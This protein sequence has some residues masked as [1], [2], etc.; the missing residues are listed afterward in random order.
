MK[1]IVKLLFAAAFAALVPVAAFAQA[2]SYPSRPIKVIVPFAPGGG[3]DAIARIV[4]QEMSK[5]LGQPIVVEHRT[6]AAGIIGI[7][8]AAKADPDGYTL[9]VLPGGHPLYSATYKMLPFDVVKSFD[10]VSTATT[11]PFV[12][13]VRDDSKIRTLADL[14]AE[15]KAKP[16]GLTFGNSGAGSTHQFT[17][18]LIA[19]R[20]GTKFISVP[21]QGE[22]AATTALLGGQID[23]LLV[24]PTQILSH[25]ESGK[26]RPLAVTGNTRFSKLPNVPT[27]EEAIGLKG[28]DI[29]TWFGLAGPAG[30]PNDVI[31]RLNAEM[32]KALANPE[33]RQRLEA[34]GG[35]ISPSTSQE[36]RDRVAREATMWNEIAKAS[37]FQK[38]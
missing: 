20:T 6:G 24:T 29:R 9:V 2:Q 27:V 26:V 13:L 7:T 17:I 22:V 25:I 19:D 12:I 8:A 14:I 28:F 16:D 5:G 18:A 37:N 38:L 1:P 34:I 31:L 36:F 35:E 15:A 10:F 4:G 33:V 32:Q 11:V 21:F 3:V 23:F 30:I